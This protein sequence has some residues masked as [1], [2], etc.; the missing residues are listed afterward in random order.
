MTIFRQPLISRETDPSQLHFDLMN[1]RNNSRLVAFLGK[2]LFPAKAPWQQ[3]TTVVVL[4]WTLAAG[5][6]SGGLIVAFL[7]FHGSR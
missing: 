2:V 7:F 3:R 6:F 5:L 1:V 4:L